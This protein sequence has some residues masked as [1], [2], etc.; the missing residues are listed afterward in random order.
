VSSGVY[1]IHNKSSHKVYIGSSLDIK[2]RWRE[3]KYKL[4]HDRHENTYLQRA[5]NKYGEDQFELVT[6]EQTDDLVNSE[7]I[8]I[9]LSKS[10][11]RRL[12]YNLYRTA[13]SPTG[14]V[15]PRHKLGKLWIVTTPDGLE[16]EVRNL[17]AFCEEKG[18]SYWSMQAVASATQEHHQDWRCRR[19][20]ESRTFHRKPRW[21]V[22][23]PDKK[24]FKI[25]NLALFC[26]EHNLKHMGMTD[27]ANGIV[28][29]HNGWTCTRL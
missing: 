24:T 17:K 14:Y 9:E 22:T 13:Y 28:K 20:G 10:Y 6:L 16:L 26:R 29:S 3:H 5:F 27:V 19:Y 21:I 2:K 18:I 4:K 15:V 7:Q 8:W 11:D 1:C 23:S 25:T 12:G